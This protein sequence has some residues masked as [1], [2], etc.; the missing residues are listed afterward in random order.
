MLGGVLNMQYSAQKVNA[1]YWTC[2]STPTASFRFLLAQT[3]SIFIMHKQPEAARI[4]LYFLCLGLI[5]CCSMQIAFILIF[6]RLVKKSHHN[7]QGK[8]RM[9]TASGGKNGLKSRK[10]Q[11]FSRHGYGRRN[12]TGIIALASLLTYAEREYSKIQ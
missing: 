2:K 7:M 1:I 9:G 3:L 4:K 10:P 11:T 12:T 6:M 5:F 8:A